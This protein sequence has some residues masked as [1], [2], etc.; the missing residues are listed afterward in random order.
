MSASASCLSPSSPELLKHSITGLDCPTVCFFPSPFT[1][2][3]MTKESLLLRLSE[4]H[5]TNSSGSILASE[6]P[7]GFVDTSNLNAPTPSNDGDDPV[8]KPK[9]PLLLT[10]PSI[11]VL[12]VLMGSVYVDLCFPYGHRSVPCSRSVWFNPLQ[13]PYPHTCRS[14]LSRAL[15]SFLLPNRVIGGG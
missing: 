11:C 15:S 14:L 7:G 3:S 12:R 6:Y 2:P 10:H 5:L 9:D 4:F 8:I 13:R 1:L